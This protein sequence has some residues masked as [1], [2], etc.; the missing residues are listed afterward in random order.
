[1]DGKALED[2]CRK[3]V[4][5]SQETGSFIR[6]QVGRVHTEQ[7]VA[8]ERNSLVSFVDTQAEQMLVDAL[9]PLLPS[10]GFLTEED[11]TVNTQGEF[12]WIID[13]LDGTTNFLQ[14]IP[15]FS[16]SV[17]LS[18]E[19]D[20]VVACVY[21]IMHDN[22]YYA[23]RGGG[24]WC[25]AS[26]IG[27][28][29]KT[30][31]SEAIIATGFPYYEPDDLPSL[32][33]ALQSFLIMARGIRRMGSAALDMTYVACGKLDGFYETAL[34]VWDIAA[35][36]LIVREAGG[37]VTDFSGDGDFVNKRRIVAANPVL[38]R[39]M[40]EALRTSFPE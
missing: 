7:I 21:D 22:T 23:W 20:I 1:M 33:H 32:V 39:A 27:V 8:K 31:L 15:M 18:H 2:I 40:I 13:P 5:I 37:V 36:T 26:R 35:G 19:G 28:S 6:S 16:V 10:P 30:D 24:A 25:D 12:T 4:R 38:H 29:A 14:Q 17:A 9:T 3:V 11:T 34:N